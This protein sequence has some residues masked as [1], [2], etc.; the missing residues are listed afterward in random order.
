MRARRVALDE[1]LKRA[2]FVVRAGSVHEAR[3]EI[4]VLILQRVH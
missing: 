2:L 4:V 1:S 3:T